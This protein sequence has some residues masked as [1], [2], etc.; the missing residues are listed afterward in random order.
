[1]TNNKNVL[2][3][4]ILILGCYALSGCDIRQSDRQNDRQMLNDVIEY[5]ETYS[6][7]DESVR[8]TDWS[9][10]PS[11]ESNGM[12]RNHVYLY[13]S[14]TYEL[15]Q[16]DKIRVTVNNYL[17]ENPDSFINSCVIFLVL[18]YSDY[19]YD[20]WD[21]SEANFVA[22]AS[23]INSFN[24]SNDEESVVIHSVNRFIIFEW[25]DNG[26]S[27]EEIK[28]SDLKDF[29][30]TIQQLKISA[31]ITYD[32]YSFLKEWDRLEYFRIDYWIISDEGYKVVPDDEQKIQEDICI[33]CGIEQ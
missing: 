13:Y 10:G 14:G 4:I 27:S 6:G 20:M 12:E 30:P 19:E 22:M 15:L 24:E 5:V 31:R 16:L 23:N 3:V 21:S 25:H 29:E 26:H 7:K 8:L 33:M 1:M 28:I 2:I 17:E 18:S 9:Y 11:K 32:D